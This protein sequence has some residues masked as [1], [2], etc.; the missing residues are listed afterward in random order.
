MSAAGEILAALLILSGGVVIGFAA[1]GV[2]RL[3]DPFMRMHA[4]TKAGVV[5]A[6][7]VLLGGGLSFGTLSGALTG[8]AGF[9]FLLV[10]APLASHALGRAAYVAGAPLSGTTTHD[11]LAGVLPRNVVDIAAARA[12][13]SREVTE[14]PVEEGAMTAIP[15]RSSP[16]SAEATDLLAVRRVTTWLIGGPS[17]PEASQLA[18][19]LARLSGAEI[20]GLTALDPAAV[21]YREPLSIG[22][23]YWMRWMA[24]RRRVAMR[25]AASQALAEFERLAAS[26]RRPATTR[27]E[28][29]DFAALAPV[30]AGSDLLVLPAGVDR[31]GRQCD[32]AEEASSM[33]ARARLAPVLRVLRRPPAVRRVLLLVG[34]TPACPRLAQGLIRAGLWPDAR[35]TVAPASAADPAQARIVAAQVELLQAHGRDAQAGQPLDADG[36]RAAMLARIRAYDAAVMGALSNRAG[37]LGALGADLHETV[38]DTAPL[39]LL[40]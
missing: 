40:P 19:D 11:A 7:F 20:T 25:Q 24:D 1:L 17:Q 33:V 29:G 36:G 30:L 28:E 18:F 21:E 3:P 34:T 27:H 12:R 15:Y 13:W 26:V 16:A 31:T 22:G 9:L 38:A 23:G 8:L 2:L 39:I 14:I 35:I 10:T 5:G 37:W 32:H 6:G 4:A